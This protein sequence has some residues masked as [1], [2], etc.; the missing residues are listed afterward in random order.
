MAVGK[1]NYLK[2]GFWCSILFSIFSVFNIYAQNYEFRLVPRRAFDQINVEIWARAV[3]PLAPKLGY[4]SFVVEYNKTY[5]TPANTQNLSVTDTITRIESSTVNPINSISSK[6]NGINGYQALASQSYGA[7]YYSLEMTLD[8][9]GQLGI[10]ADSIG[11]GSFVGK[12][13]F[14]IIGNPSDSAL[15]KIAWSKSILPGDIRIFDA[16][17]NDIESTALMINPD[18]LYKVT[19]ITILNPNFLGVVVDRDQSYPMLDGD[20]LDGGYP[21]YFERS[22][23]PSVYTVPN[24]PPPSVDEDLAYLFEYS[25]DDGSSW[26]EIGRAAESD[27][28]SSTIG[29]NPFFRSGEIFDAKKGSAFIISAQNGAPLNATTFRQP[30]RALWVKNSNFVERSEQARLRI[31]RLAG[32]SNSAITLR[33]PDGVFDINDNK[34]I[35]GRLFF[36][37]LN[38][39]NQYL[40]TNDMFSNPTQITVEAWINLNTYK[41]AG[42]EPAIVASSGGPGTGVTFGSNEGAWMLYLKDG[43]IPAFRVRE[44]SSRG[45]S[46]GSIYMA[47]LSS[48]IQDSLRAV[49][50]AEPLTVE[51][52]KNWVHL[53]ATVKDNT[54][55]LYVNGEQADKYENKTTTDIRMMTTNHPIWVGVNPNGTIDDSD[56]L[57]AGI[58]GVRVWRTALSQND[59]RTLA[60]GINNA[61][62]ISS[63]SDIKKG[64]ELYYSLEGSKADLATDTLYQ[65]RTNDINFY[66]SGVLNPNL[67]SYR[68]DQPHIKI[69]SPQTNAGVLNKQGDVFQIRWISYGLGDISNTLSKDIDIEYTL[70]DADSWNYAKSPS[71]QN[72]GGT[73][74]PDVETAATNWEPYLNN[75]TLANLRTISPY[76]KRTFLRIRGT[77]ANTQE[78]LYDMAGPFSVAPYFGIVIENSRLIVPGTE[79][80]NING[81]TSMFDMWIKPYRFPTDVEGY[82]PIL[83]KIDSVADISHYSLRL[84]ST[85]QLE[86]RLTDKNGNIRN[87]ISDSTKPL[88]RPNSVEKDSIW[89]H[90]AVFFS[91][92]GSLGEA[93]V[94]FYIDGTVQSGT[95]L[96]KQI[97]DSIDINSLNTYPLFIG[98]MPQIA[99]AP[100]FN[101]I[102]EIKE[103]RFW[104]GS[105]N[106]LS[107]AGAEPTPLTQFIQSAQAVPTKQLLS[108]NKTNLHSAFSFNGGGFIINGVTR[109]ISISENNLSVVKNLGIPLKYIAAEPFIK[110]VEPVFKQSVDNSNTDLRL[111]W[112]G[113]YY[114]GVSFVTGSPLTP[115]SLEFSIRGGGGA[116][117]QP[118]QYIGS[119]YWL[120][121]TTD[122]LKLPVDDKFRIKTNGNDIYYAASMNVALSDPDENNDGIFNDQAP[123]AASLTN[124]RLR[125]TGRYNINGETKL[126]QA[127]GPLFT[128]TPS[129]NFTVRVLLEGYHKGGAANSLLTNLASTYDR[130]GLRIQLYKDNSNEIGEKVGKIV[131]SKNGYLDRDPVN[132]R[133]GNNKFANVN[134]VYTDLTNGNYWVLVEHINHL[135]IM[136]RFPAK[137]EFTGDIA[138]TWDIESGWDFTS[139]NGVDNNVMMSSDV[140]PWTAFNYT[141]KGSSISTKSLPEY[142]TTGLVFNGG[143]IGQVSP[144]PAM[145]GGDVNQ[146]KQINSADRVLVRQDDGTSNPRSDITGDNVVNALDRTITDRNYGKV[147]SVYNITFPQKIKSFTPSD[148]INPFD[149]T[150]PENPEM[151]KYFN[152]NA[153]IV[154]KNKSKNIESDKVL[155]GLDYTVSAKTI[156]DDNYVYLNF[157]I[158]NNGSK[159]GLANCTF[160]VKYNTSALEFASLD[161]KDSVMFSNKPAVGYSQLRSAPNNN[162]E[163]PLLDVRSIEVDYDAFA[164]LGGES[165]P[166]TSTF[167]GTLRFKLVNKNSSIAFSWYN[168]TAV[169][170]TDGRDATKFGKFLTIDGLMLYSTKI[171]FPNGGEQLSPK[172]K[173]TIKWT[174]TGSANIFLEYSTNAGAD[175][176]RINVDPIDA[177]VKQLEWTTPDVVSSYCLVRIIDAASNTE[178]SRSDTYFSIVPSFAQIIRPGS[179]DPVYSGGINDK[180]RWSANGVDKVRF[181]FSSDAGTNWKSISGTILSEQA[182]TGWKLP[183]ITTK[184]AI[185]RMLD[186]E[187]NEEIARTGRFKIL[188]GNVVFRSPKAG[189]TLIVDKYYKVSWSSQNV[190]TFDLQLSTDDGFNWAPEKSSVQAPALSLTWQVPNSPSEKAVLRALWMGDPEMEYGRTEV[191][192]IYNAT[193][194]ED[195]LPAGYQ[196]GEIFPNPAKDYIS[197]SLNIPEAQTCTLNVYNSA[198]AEIKS[199][200][201]FFDEKSICKLDV[202]DLPQGSY[203]LIISSEKFKVCRQFNK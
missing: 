196:A 34:F 126:I 19:G 111:R 37:Q 122:A 177:A 80:M 69:T 169:L 175:W 36:L 92:N 154:F 140:N 118:Y 38:G 9:L 48:Y 132:K 146:D 127:E 159:F 144:L 29:N 141:A 103:L 174:S 98:Y 179:A 134:F 150:A 64:L 11:K 6:F 170:T 5:L 49:S 180:I 65:N 71:N 75:N 202:T 66:E 192:K 182:E 83:E 135:P 77:A 62:K 59:I 25:L 102:G 191:F 186:A 57:N 52:S 91:R 2:T 152:D 168:S 137:F 44:I 184:S 99:G 172:K 106:N 97:G 8:K 14:N 203:I 28:S 149:A 160:A 23:N 70:D 45:D 79:A 198:G 117:I 147:S 27:R 93:D 167:L 181:E 130:G 82:F 120:G 56:Y 10:T 67:K 81:N 124:A 61:N 33:Q 26:K 60:A 189:E 7:G 35:L 54:A 76:S 89:N 139:W 136:S 199:K 3:N 201:V 85:G 176:S 31:S 188:Y 109:S 142:S 4:G 42:S 17:G 173:A 43:S 107:A 100:S 183:A 112:V 84:L 72:L 151:S 193:S 87:A 114:D 16:A 138:S 86:F 125:L 50:A 197:L 78:N 194:V 1:Y 63:Y 47:Q 90:V 133:A 158:K 30:L 32:T 21:I 163:N 123:L 105:P 115:P 119:D 129:S 73:T 12:I 15:A 190:E 96:A 162:S 94:K 148:L 88:V 24:G 101:F 161:G 165:V 153:Q 157:Y 51:H 200:T 155:A 110:F 113:N 95:D 13:S 58:K 40:K 22:V 18:S 164:N 156:V 185:V 53:A 104:Q 195:N 55:I 116:V 68:P 121:N 108:S 145:V 128:I 20:Y 74:A 143:V 46:S 39:T 41:A 178:T 171:V 187:T 131:E 166:D